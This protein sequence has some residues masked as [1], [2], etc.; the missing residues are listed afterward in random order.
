MKIELRRQM[1]IEACKSIMEIGKFQ[2]EYASVLPVLMLTEEGDLTPSVVNSKLFSTAPDDPRGRYLLERLAEYRLIERSKTLAIDDNSIPENRVSPTS[3]ISFTLSESIGKYDLTAL[4]EQFIPRL[5]EYFFSYSEMDNETRTVMEKLAEYGILSSVPDV[6]PRGLFSTDDSRSISKW[7][8]PKIPEEEN[9]TEIIKKFLTLDLVQLSRASVSR[10]PTQKSDVNA[11]RGVSDPVYTLTD[12]G[13]VALT[14][15]R[16]PIPEKGVYILHGTSDPVLSNP[17]ISCQPETTNQVIETERPDNRKNHHSPDSKRPSHV[18]Y[19][20]LARLQEK[21]A[22]GPLVLNIP[23]NSNDPLQIISIDKSVEPA[24]A[25]V[26]ATL[27]LTL[28]Y[29]KD[30]VARVSTAGNS[31]KNGTASEA[32]SVEHKFS[33]DFEDV[34]R[35]LFADKIDDVHKDD[36]GFALLV[37]F[38]DVKIKPAILANRRM[39]YHIDAPEI[40]N[41]GNFEGLTIHDL[42]VAPRTLTDARAWADWCFHDKIQY[43][44]THENYER[45]RQECAGIWEPRFSEEEIIDAIPAYEDAIRIC[46]RGEMEDRTLFWFLMTPYLLTMKEVS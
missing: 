10:Q 24:N 17:V 20:W 38:D 5:G 11:E 4:G 39:D 35:S 7:T 6:N 16:V 45:L 42:H 32:I 36:D 46:E 43:H 1:N 15:G 21:I 8:W 9:E 2:P 28:E 27:L 41:F 19:P 26:S 13:R 31:K 37:S 22:S 3:D 25:K 29:Q 34:V 23:H 33:L 30:P 40:E 44:I 12:T 14:E 18:D